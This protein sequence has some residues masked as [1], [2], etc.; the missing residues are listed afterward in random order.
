MTDRTDDPITIVRQRLCPLYFWKIKES[1]LAAKRWHHNPPQ[2][3]EV[4]RL[5]RHVANKLK[6][7]PFPDNI[8]RITACPAP[9][10]AVA[11]QA[12]RHRP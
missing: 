8:V 7:T 3:R 2:I 6:E 1:L 12:L 5:W 4:F 11:S 10:V 9:P